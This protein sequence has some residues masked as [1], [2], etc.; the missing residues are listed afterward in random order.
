MC[1]VRIEEFDRCAVYA[2]EKSGQVCCVRI[3]KS[4]QM[5]C[6]RIEKLDRCAVYALKSWTGV[7]K[8]H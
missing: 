6:V 3:E 5:C 8:S 2:L 1:F 7:L 4:G